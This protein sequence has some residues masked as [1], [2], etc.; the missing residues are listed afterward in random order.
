MLIGFKQHNRYMMSQELYI[1]YWKT[2]LIGN[3]C[4]GSC[5]ASYYVSSDQFLKERLASGWNSYLA[6]FG[7]S[8]IVFFSKYDEKNIKKR[9]KETFSLMKNISWQIAWVIQFLNVS[10]L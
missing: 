9:K 6:I 1:N 7:A 4:L 5:A 8:M 2:Y 10:L 3:N